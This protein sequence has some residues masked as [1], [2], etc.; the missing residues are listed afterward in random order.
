MQRHV[1]RCVDLCCRFGVGRHKARILK[2]VRAQPPWSGAPEHPGRGVGCVGGTRAG[3]GRPAAQLWAAAS[4]AKDPPRAFYLP[5]RGACLLAARPGCLGTRPRCAHAVPK[6][7]HFTVHEHLSGRSDAPSLFLAS[8][9]LPVPASSE[10]QSLSSQSALH[11]HLLAA[12]SCG[13]SQA[14]VNWDTHL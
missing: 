12:P 2:A 14:R 3:R 4:K 13:L 8:L 11:I 1:V 7:L 6:L 10:L 5:P 9:S